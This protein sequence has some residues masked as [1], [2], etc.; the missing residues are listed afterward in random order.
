MQCVR[1]TGCK[2]LRRRGCVLRSCCCVNASGR[3]W[4]RE[5]VRVQRECCSCCCQQHAVRRMQGQCRGRQQEHVMGVGRGWVRRRL[6]RVR[7]LLV[8]MKLMLNAGVHLQLKCRLRHAAQP[9]SILKQPS[10]SLKQLQHN[11]KVSR[12]QIRVLQDQVT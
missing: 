3:C 9:S 12:H 1:H 10:H 4:S 8:W 6:I 5:R 2:L 7:L 11:L